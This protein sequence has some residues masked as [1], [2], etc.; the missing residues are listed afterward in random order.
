MDVT[1]FPHSFKRK[2]I[3]FAK[4][5]DSALK[6]DDIHTFP[7]IDRP[8]EKS[9]KDGFDLLV[10]LGAIETGRGKGGCHAIP[11]FV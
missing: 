1:P 5:S 7:F 9:I 6:L 11:A 10:E 4:F 2:I 3:G 8:P